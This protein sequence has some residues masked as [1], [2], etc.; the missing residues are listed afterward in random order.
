MMSTIKD[1][2]RR[3]GDAVYTVGVD[4]TVLKALRLM[5]EHDLG[6]LVVMEGESV[7]GMFS[8]RDYA[9]KI[10]LQGHSSADTKVREIM[11]SPVL[12]VGPSETIEEGMALMT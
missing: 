7:V 4:D 10:I 1:V 3:K 11:S 12:Y 6:A 5:A 2:L 8:E 9:R